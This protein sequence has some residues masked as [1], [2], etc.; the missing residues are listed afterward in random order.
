MNIDNSQLLNIDIYCDN[1][2]REYV[3]DETNIYIEASMYGNTIN[4][5]CPCGNEHELSV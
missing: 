3:I 1:H 2:Q 4:V 5:I